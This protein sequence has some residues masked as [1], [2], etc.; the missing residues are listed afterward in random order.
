MQQFYANRQPLDATAAQTIAAAAT[1]TGAASDTLIVCRK[2]HNFFRA[3]LLAAAPRAK[4]TANVDVQF[5]DVGD[6]A[7]VEWPQQV[8][9][10][11]RRFAQLE[12]QAIGCSMPALQLCSDHATIARSVERYMNGGKAAVKTMFVSTKEVGDDASDVVNGVY[13]IVDVHVG[14]VSLCK[15]LENDGLVLPIPEGEFV[16]VHI[17]SVGWKY[18]NIRDE[19]SVFRFPLFLSEFYQ[20]INYCD[21]VISYFTIDRCEEY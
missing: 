18:E 13:A 21:T 7:T 16:C 14:D 19:C 12:R 8:W 15:L 4:Q 1:A 11:D 5:I 6:Q 2:A 9:P 10:L 3:R 20:I 17:L